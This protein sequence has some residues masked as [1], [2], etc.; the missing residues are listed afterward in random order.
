M[1]DQPTRRGFVL[2][3]ASLLL[4]LTLAPGSAEAR[5]RRKSS[6]GKK[7]RSSGGG[8]RSRSSSSAPSGGFRNCAEA[9]AAGAAPVRSGD[10][11]YSR[12][13]DRDGDGVACE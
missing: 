12:K 11:G 9:R 7:R 6:G 2:G 10:A 4:G 5:R 13:L 8:S 3:A 1:N